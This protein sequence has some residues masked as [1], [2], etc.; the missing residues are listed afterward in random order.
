MIAHRVVLFSPDSSHP[1]LPP[2]QDRRP[3]PKI[4]EAGSSRDSHSQECLQ[5]DFGVSGEVSLE[6]H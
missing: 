2:P 3:K 6:Q 4:S 5:R 1:D